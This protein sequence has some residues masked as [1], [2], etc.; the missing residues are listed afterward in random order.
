LPQEIDELAKGGL[1]F[2][3]DSLLLVWTADRNELAMVLARRRRKLP[4]AKSIVDLPQNGF[5]AF[6]GF[7]R[8]ANGKFNIVAS[9]C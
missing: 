3:H 8:Q 9:Y 4:V 1:L 7:G 5:G 6:A 2:P